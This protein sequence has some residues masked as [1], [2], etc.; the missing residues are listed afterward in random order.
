MN[1]NRKMYVW[2]CQD[3]GDSNFRTRPDEPRRCSTCG[4]RGAQTFKWFLIHGK[5]VQDK[6][7]SPTGGNDELL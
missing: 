5:L 4:N 1:R 7:Q 2:M 3:C 6:K